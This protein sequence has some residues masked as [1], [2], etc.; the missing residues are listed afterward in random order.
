[1]KEILE[2]IKNKSIDLSEMGVNNFALTKKDALKLLE[3]FKENNIF[4]YGGD[5]LEKQN[6]KINYNYINWS[7]NGKNIIHNLEYAENFIKK[8]AKDTMYIEFVTEIDLYNL[9]LSSQED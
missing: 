5:F 8:Y 3:K 1:M 9:V 6:K 2:F 7:T 4:L